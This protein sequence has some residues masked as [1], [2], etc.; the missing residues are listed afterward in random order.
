MQRAPR[1]S[2]AAGNAALQWAAG[3]GEADRLIATVERHARKIQRRRR[4]RVVAA[5]AALLV[6][7]GASVWSL[8]APAPAVVD[9]ALPVSAVV[10]RPHTE[11]LPDGSVVELREGARISV[12]F[13]GDIRRITLDAGE[14]H[15]QVRKDA[16]RPFIVTA[17]GVEVKAVGTA[18]SVGLGEAA[19]EIV[20]T[21]GRVAVAGPNHAGGTWSPPT[22]DAGERATVVLTA[23]APVAPQVQPMAVSE[24]NQRLAWRVPRLDFDRT[25]LREALALFNRYGSVQLMLDNP[26]LGALEV[27]GAV[28]ADDTESLLMLLRNEF[29][30]SAE[31]RGEEI[32]LRRL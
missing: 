28:K 31:K 1:S 5:A 2:D 21:E 16:A 9:A 8:R 19:V 30:I 22:I 14:A 17:S 13:S 27:S 20:V 10:S 18:F 32:H 6:V 7:V 24:L 3:T 4:L 15:F 11:T 23:S 29:G 12:A 26:A 25:P